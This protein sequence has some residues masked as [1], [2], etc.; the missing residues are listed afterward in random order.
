MIIFMGHL[1]QSL[2][3]YDLIFQ[4]FIHAFG[5]QEYKGKYSHLYSEMNNC[6]NLFY[7][8]FPNIK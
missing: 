2:K 5:E 3:S 8:L 7:I 6:Y 1:K 4:Y